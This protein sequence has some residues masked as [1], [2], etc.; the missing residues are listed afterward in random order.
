MSPKLFW[1]KF[2]EECFTW[3]LMIRS[4]K[5]EEKF[6]NCKSENFLQPCWE[7]HLRINSYQSIEL[8]KDLPL[9]LMVKRF[10]WSS[11]VQ[12]LSLILSRVINIL[13]EKLTPQIGDWIWKAP[14]AHYFSGVGISCKACL[15]FLNFFSGDLFVDVLIIGLF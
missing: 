8:W 4:C 15:L 5:G 9:R 2:M 10:Q 6:Q 14:C 13:F 7:T 12:F 11:Q 3:K 1:G